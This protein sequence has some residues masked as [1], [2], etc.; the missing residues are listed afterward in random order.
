MPEIEEELAEHQ[1]PVIFGVS[2]PPFYPP[3]SP[4]QSAGPRQ[5]RI[6]AVLVFDLNFDNF[7][8][9]MFGRFWIVLGRH[10]GVMLG[11]FGVQVGPSSVQ[12]A[13]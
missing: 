6:T 9:S 12:N 5:K 4:T 10:L 8:T 3:K 7:L 2:S 1:F 13:S 11:T